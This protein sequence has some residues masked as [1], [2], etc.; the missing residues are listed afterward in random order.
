MKTEIENKIF[1]LKYLKS[2]LD[3]LNLAYG[4]R[5]VRVQLCDGSMYYLTRQQNYIFQQYMVESA[6]KYFGIN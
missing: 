6:N 1:E 3:K 5:V 2:Y 4:D